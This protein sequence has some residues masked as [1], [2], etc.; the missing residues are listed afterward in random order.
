MRPIAF[1]L[2]VA[3]AVPAAADHIGIYTDPSAQSC[4]GPLGYYSPVWVYV[5][6]ENGAGAKGSK[7][8]VAHDMPLVLL[9]FNTGQF[10]W[11]FPPGDPLGTGRVEGYSECRTIPYVIG[12]LGFYNPGQPLPAGCDHLRVEPHQ[13]DAYTG[14]ET[15]VVVVDCAGVAQPATGGHFSFASPLDCDDCGRPLAVEATTWG[16]VKALYR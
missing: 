13:G 15:T 3:L 14:P 2:A 10:T 7:W 1:L 5:I 11:P 8:R 4:V 12:E 16:S 6:H 9:A